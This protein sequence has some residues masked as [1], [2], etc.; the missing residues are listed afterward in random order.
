MKSLFGS[1]SCFVGK[2]LSLL[3]STVIMLISADFTSMSAQSK[4]TTEVIGVVVD[5]NDEPMPGV[6]VY[7]EDKSTG[8]ISGED[9]RY[10]VIIDA[11]ITSLHFSFLGYQ[12]QVVDIR[13]AALVKMQPDENAIAETV[14]TGIY[15]R[16]AES[17]TGAVQTISADDLKRVGN[18]N[19]FQSLK[20]L[21]PSLLIL[22]NLEQGSNPNA[23][24][25]MQLRGASSFGMETTSLKSNFVSDA[26]MPLFILDGFETTVERIQDMDMNRIQSITILKDASAKAIYGT[27][28]GNGV[29]VIE[30]KALRSDKPLVT[31]VG[32]V[33]VEMPDL[34]SYNLCNALEKLEVE[35][36]EGY[37]TLPLGGASSQEV[38][39]YTK[40]YY[41]RLHRAMEGES[42]YWLSKPL[43]LGIGQQHSL[44]VE[45]GEK[46]LKTLVAFSYNNN[47]GAMKGSF[48]EVINGDVQV[49]YRIK[50]WSFRNIMSISH[51]NSEDSPYGTF[52]AYAKM[53]PY[54]S[55]YDE[56]GNIIR[57]YIQKKENDFVANPLYDATL[58]TKLYNGYLDFT[59]NLYIEYKPWDFIKFVGRVGINTKRTEDEEFYP[60]DHSKFI[61]DIDN[62]Q[63]DVLLSRGTY[64]ATNG[65]YTKL[66]ADLSVQVNK[67]FAGAHDLFLTGQYSVETTNYS[68]VT[69]Y[70]EGFPNSN[71]NS[72]IFA[73]Q[74]AT[75]RVPTG[76]DGLNRS[77]G[78][79]LTG[80]YSYKN[81]YMVDLTGKMS[82]SS[83]FG[84]DNK[85]ANFWSLGL[86][87]NLHNEPF[88]SRTR[89]WL[90][91]FKLRASVGTSGNQNYTTNNSLPVYNYYSDSYYNGFTG[92]YVSNM[93]NPTLGWEQ[94]VDYNVGLDI[95]TK[96]VD[97]TLDAYIKDTENLAFNRSIL[98]STG[99]T[100]V[101]DN[102]G[103]V[104][105]KG[106][107]ASANYRIFQTGTSYLAVFGKIALNDNRVLK[108]SEA[109]DNYN[110]QQQKN[111]E[112][113]M[114]LTP[115]IQY[116]DGMPLNSI[117]AVPSLGIDPITGD[118]I[119]VDREGNITNEWNAANL[120][121]CGSSDP[122]YNGNFGLNGE[123]HGFG[124]SVVFTFYGGG[125]QYNS[126]LVDRVENVNI[127]DNVDR[128]IFS[129]R[130][131]EK[132]QVAQYRDG[133]KN[134]SSGNSRTQAT[135]R[136]VQKNNVMKLS[137]VSL[138]YD[139]PY[140]WIEKAKMQRLRLSLYANDL[141]TFSSIE[142]ER[143]TSYPYART[144]SFSL[145]VTF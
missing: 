33:D 17:F 35:R 46:D 125:Y 96:H 36:R 126:T 145:N 82:A 109:L 83:V 14:V 4:K 18:Q 111:A 57:Y 19:V 74:Y 51:M 92:A 56:N 63:D 41:D 28:A 77:L 94:N 117:W 84:T 48:R 38:S 81:R 106:I 6:S 52:D 61:D 118:E 37:Y 127:E 133:Y 138:Y 129:G 11:G 131:F 139:F 10:A 26:N 62:T 1:A 115:V 124:L 22:D 90:H 119:F 66:S 73:R 54:F 116:Y 40:L 105:N 104:R 8:T 134:D 23:M 114:Q 47:Q 98:P 89:S 55:P 86:A 31:Y 122:L 16:K 3:L 135:T 45:L 108:I 2:V 27:K 59:D 75:D 25:S 44:T 34:S 123:L 20:N 76:A 79:L 32:S 9:G 65:K 64:D 21:D 53:N 100:S 7:T 87:W 132:G 68:E 58:G 91:Q 128:R 15:E 107:E 13:N 141:A 39:N 71:M 30:T 113:N 101:T 95:R 93:E 85:W 103:L 110:K 99:F 49:S 12:D 60:A 102:M 78:F 70:T 50:K 42:T 142:I 140:K 43:R 97:V 24:A 144:L 88:M 67:S 5:E 137:S 69:H 136:F 121:N 80:G 29:I 130:W 143:G 120:V 72:I 112:D